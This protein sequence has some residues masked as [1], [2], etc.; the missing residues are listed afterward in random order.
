MFFTKQ[1]NWEKGIPQTMAS[2]GH[3][4]Q[5]DDE[6]PGLTEQFPQVT[7]FLSDIRH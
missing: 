4:K 6:K 7:M 2:E 5:D 1:P 3:Y